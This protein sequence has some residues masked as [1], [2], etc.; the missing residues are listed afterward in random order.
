[1]IPHGG[2]VLDLAAGSG[3]HTKLLAESGYSVEAVDRDIS[4]LAR[5]ALLPT[6]SI[7]EW[8]LEVGVWPYSNEHFAGIVVTNYLQRPI[9]PE[10]MKALVPGG[11]LIYETFAL[12][13]EAYGRP[14]NP[15]FLL[16]PGELL[17]VV[18]GQ[19]RVLAFEDVYTAEPK[20]AMV[21][22]IC[23]MRPFA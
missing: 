15:D 5:L 12:G 4:K 22:R 23:A 2:R 19:L 18:H 10:L 1:M 16:R 11:V 6:V 17:D 20:P 21:Q 14:A 9:F 3:R 7:Y 13:N 8:D